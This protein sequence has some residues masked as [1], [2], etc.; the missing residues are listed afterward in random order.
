M[1]KWN[2]EIQLEEKYN[3]LTLARIIKQKSTELSLKSREN[4]EA[5]FLTEST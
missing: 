2:L 1:V 4:R 5:K 3:P